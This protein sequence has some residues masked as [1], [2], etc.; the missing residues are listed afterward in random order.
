M[1]FLSLLAPTSILI[2]SGE[3][4]QRGF[5]LDD[6]WIHMVYGR[7]VAQ[8][9]FL[10]YN[11]GIPSTG[12]TSPLW[13]YFLGLVHLLFQ[14][15]NSII[16][17][18]KILGIVLHA[19]MAF[20]AFKIVIALTRSELTGLLAALFVGLCPPLVISSISGMEVPLGC[21]LLLAGA[22]AYLKQQWTISGIF[23]GLS[24]LT[25]PEFGAVII[26]FAVDISLRV[27]KKRL[28]WKRLVS[29]LFPPIGL[30][31]IN[32]GWNML[33]DGR[34]FPATFYVKALP[35]VGL[36]LVERFLIGLSMI[37]MKSSS[38]A[39]FAWLGLFFLPL[40]KA[41]E[42]KA[43]IY[44][45]GMGFAYFFGSLTMISPNDPEAFYYLRY[46]LPSVPLL[47]IGSVIALAFGL[48]TTWMRIQTKK[49]PLTRL[50]PAIFKLPVGLLIVSVCIQILVGLNYWLSKYT[51]DCRNINEVQAELGKAISRGFKEDA[52]VGTIDAGAIRYFGKRK[53]LDLIGLN[54]KNLFNCQTEKDRL[55]A[56]VLMPAWVKLPRQHNLEVIVAKR[57]LDYR[58]TSNP[59]MGRQFIA[60]CRS[61]SNQPTQ[62]L[63][64]HVLGRSLRVCLKCFNDQEISQLKLSI[65]Q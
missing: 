46:F 17:G 65:G 61:K 57:T 24:G 60:V 7:S 14:E 40:I 6:A 21:T 31:M 43:A 23:L 13:A 54:T 5:P 8:G 39:C 28:A 15:T 33:V 37:K 42:K 16:W 53:T 64:I 4:G 55:D 25:R 38:I 20:L 11:K 56:L 59:L 29:L 19:I 26:L 2:L 18:T 22:H 35:N 41:N 50:Q 49:G 3:H 63:E 51:G 48:K 30:G 10:A 47:L 34:P 62:D 52:V 1:L 32:L 27:L 44:F 12:C 58:V 45:Y 9:G 36:N